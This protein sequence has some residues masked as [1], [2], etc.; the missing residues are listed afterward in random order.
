MAKQTYTVGN[1]LAARLEQMGIKHYF[2]VPGDYNLVLLD[3]LLWDK[4]MQLISCCNELNAA[5]TAEGYARING[6]GAVIV[7]FNV[8]AF[9]ALNGIGSA[10]AEN[11]PVIFVSSSY[12]TND[13]SAD[14]LLHHTLGTHD[15]TYQREMM[16]KVTCEAV[17]IHHV[18]EAPHLIDRAIRTALREHKPAYIEIP[19]NLANLPCSEPVPF[20]TLMSTAQSDPKTLAAAVE[21][22]AK[23]LNG[24]RK[25]VLLAGSK[26]RAYGAIDAFRGLAEALGCGVAVM[27]D[28]KGFFPEDHPQY[29]GVYWGSVSSPGCEPIV[30]EADAILAAGP[31][32]TDY[33]TAGWTALPPQDRTINAHPG[34]VRFPRAEYSGVE[35]ADFLSSLAKQVRKNDATLV[36]YRNATRSSK[37]PIAPAGDANAS[38]TRVEMV[39]QIQNDIDGKTTLLVETGDAWFEGIYMRLPG[40]ARFE[41]EMLWGSIG[42][43]VPATFGYALGLEPGRRIV[44]MIG[45]GSFR[46]TAQEVATM[47][48]HGL[49]NIT[50]FLINNHGYVVESVIHDGPYNY[51][52]EWDYA[53]LVKVLNAEDGHGLGLKA[54]TVGELANAIK[55]AREHTAGP[56]LIECQIAHDDFSPQM[57]EWGKKVAKANSRPPQQ[58]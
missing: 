10:F 3:Q 17:W 9:S 11:L 34:F 44:S 4:N 27:P 8:G 32:Y 14:R 26:L 54:R 52:K 33:S 5:Y 6:A 30:N 28:A 53:G 23:L 25:P 37:E 49:K 48:G 58:T 45:D 35:L 36:Q 40:G 29:M 41:I 38:L 13:Q 56:V 57:L 24:S 15:L 46:F 20:E 12:N 21:A 31:I 39:R 55:K 47:I 50:I 19:C 2:V 22:A 42:W 1:Y 7:T 16:R 18:A 51:Y 43:S